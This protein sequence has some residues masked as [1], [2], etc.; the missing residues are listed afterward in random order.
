[1]H[2]SENLG[3]TLRIL[4]GKKGSGAIQSRLTA[5]ERFHGEILES[6]KTGSY[7]VRLKGMTVSA[8]SILNLL[9]GK[10][11]LFEAES[12]APQIILKAVAP[13]IS[14]TQSKWSFLKELN[15]PADGL[16]E[17]ALDLLLFAGKVPS[18]EEIS[19]LAA[20]VN[21]YQDLFPAGVEA[22]EMLQIIFM[23]ETLSL[24]VKKETVGF[25]MSFMRGEPRLGDVLR[26]FSDFLKKLLREAEA[27]NRFDT[28]SLDLL[29]NIKGLLER[30]LHAGPP[31][32]FSRGPLQF[33]A[34]L[35]MYYETQLR[36]LLSGNREIDDDPF[37][38]LKAKLLELLLFAAEDS[39]SATM[40]AAGSL[41][42]EVRTMLGAIEDAQVF[43][44]LGTKDGSWIVSFLQIPVAAEDG[45]HLLPVMYQ[46][47]GKSASKAKFW[48]L[49]LSVHFIE[50]G[51]LYINLS[52]VR[53]LMTAK[54]V[55]DNEQYGDFLRREVRELPG[56][57]KPLG[58][59]L[60]NVSI[61]YKENVVRERL[62]SMTADLAAMDQP[63]NITV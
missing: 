21:A 27:G 18:R 2:I 39:D 31:S 60:R 62:C 56:M 63:V 34:L 51:N 53:E 7:S 30:L 49:H 19:A 13:N 6:D 23:L 3:N 16:H 11:Y 37:N 58:Y 55:T 22:E 10:T 25:L 8:K 35:G 43:R 47:R 32:P 44:N 24:P 9:P 15:L 40:D 42:R 5:H 4:M 26:E 50:T 1:M 29:N 52:G 17:T 28:R 48:K 57:V 20:L 45:M 14:E 46:R 36:Y 41:S 59:V 12:L 61:V 33:S 38:S 54:I